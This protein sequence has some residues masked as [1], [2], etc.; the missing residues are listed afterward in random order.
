MIAY[1]REEIFSPAQMA[2]R[3]GEILKKLGN[4]EISKA[5]ISK[6]NTI[7]AVLL[8]VEEYEKMQST[9]EMIEM[10]RTGKRESFFGS[11]KGLIVMGAKFDEPVEDF[12]EYM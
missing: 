11:A 2:K 4:K 3:F 7:E 5:A 8:P 10:K 1:S 9:C 12:K 6:N